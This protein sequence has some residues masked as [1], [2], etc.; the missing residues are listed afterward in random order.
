MSCSYIPGSTN[1]VLLQETNEGSE[2]LPLTNKTSNQSGKGSTWSCSFVEYGILT[3][4]VCARSLSQS[5]LADYEQTPQPSE[6][7]LHENNTSSRV[8]H[9]GTMSDCGLD[10]TEIALSLLFAYSARASPSC[11]AVLVSMLC[12]YFYRP[13]SDEYSVTPWTA[14]SQ[15]ECWSMKKDICRIEWPIVEQYFAARSTCLTFPDCAHLPNITT[16]KDGDTRE[17][18]LARVNSVQL[19]S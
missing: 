13:C 18:S 17:V 10:T 8:V 2:E 1:I 3:T 16:D 6:I 11:A 4:S 15:D 14:V 5:L 12:R 19:C 9:V 7:S